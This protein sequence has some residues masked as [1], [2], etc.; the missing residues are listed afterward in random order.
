MN[1]RGIK[2]S[3]RCLKCLGSQ[4]LCALVCQYF[5]E[6]LCLCTPVCPPARG[7]QHRSREGLDLAG[8]FVSTELPLSCHLSP[9]LLVLSSSFFQCCFSPAPKSLFCFSPTGGV[10]L[11]PLFSNP[12]LLWAHLPL[13]T[14]PWNR[15]PEHWFPSTTKVRIKVHFTQ[16]QA[17]RAADPGYG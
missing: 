11:V 8:T 13:L 12:L 6:S 17:L 10:F 4:C 5:S 14:V 16:L 7:R 3:M 9:P 1:Y 15:M 2:G